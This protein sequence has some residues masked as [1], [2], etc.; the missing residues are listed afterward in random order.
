[1]AIGVIR[2]NSKLL[3]LF[4][5]ISITMNSSQINTSTE[6]LFMTTTHPPIIEIR[7]EPKESE[8]NSM[9]DR[10]K[11]LDSQGR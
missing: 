2:E 7:E 9:I 1:M 8:S 5:N 4:L 11:P 3:D 10:G 6:K